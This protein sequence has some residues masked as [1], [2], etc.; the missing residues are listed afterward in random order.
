MFTY[1]KKLYEWL[2]KQVYSP[3]ADI[4]LGCMF[5]VEAIF[6]LPTD[7][8]LV[9]YCLERRDRAFWYALIATIG[10]VLGGITSYALGY[11]I[12]HV[13]GES[14]IH[15]PLLNR[16]VKPESFLYLC[17]CYRNYQ[18]L[19]LLVAGFT[20][21]PFKAVTFTA[22]FCQLSL[23]PFIFYSFIVRGV[24]FF[25]VAAVIS[26]WG[27]QMKQF[28]DQYFKVLVALGILVVCILIGLIRRSHQ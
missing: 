5:Y 15:Y 6:F 16:L 17:A 21:I 26:K 20:P 27:A 2:G 9:L 4:L 23:L 13:A 8:I 28:I 7:P 22:G 12:W 11:Y 3:Y 19:A 1:I 14:I 25:L 18:S 10:S 24:R